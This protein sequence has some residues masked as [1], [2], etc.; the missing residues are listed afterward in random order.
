MGYAG[1]GVVVGWAGLRGRGQW[2]WMVPRKKPFKPH[3][4]CGSGDRVGME[5]G[6]AARCLPKDV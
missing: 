1:L 2:E 5:W 6:V 4:G 3:S